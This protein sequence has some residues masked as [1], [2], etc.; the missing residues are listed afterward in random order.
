[1]RFI[2]SKPQAGETTAHFTKC[3]DLDEAP[4]AKGKF[5][6]AGGGAAVHPVVRR[7]ALPPD[8][9]EF[10][11]ASREADRLTALERRQLE[12]KALVERFE[13]V[14]QQIAAWKTKQK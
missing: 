4:I 14:K 9:R 11:G 1:M 5:M 3:R 10:E 7:E 6:I 8:L 2:I 13:I 12:I